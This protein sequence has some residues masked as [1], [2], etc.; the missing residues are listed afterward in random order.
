ML[1]IFILITI[2]VSI[3]ELNSWL[4]IPYLNMFIGLIFFLGG[5]LYL[6]LDSEFFSSAIGLL[7]FL[8]GFDI[9]YSS[10]EGSALVT[11]IYAAITL[12]IAFIYSYLNAGSEK[13]GR[14]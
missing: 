12:L 14:I 3:N 5:F 1:A 8:A 2:A 7:T 13:E 11:G 4:P 9:L 6:G 10:L